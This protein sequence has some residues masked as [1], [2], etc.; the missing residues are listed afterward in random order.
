MKKTR[1]LLSALLL[2]SFCFPARAEDVKTFCSQTCSLWPKLCPTGTLCVKLCKIPRNL[3]Q[4]CRDNKMPLDTEIPAIPLTR[5]QFC[6]HFCK[7]PPFMCAAMTYCTQTCKTDPSQM[8]TCIQQRIPLD[9]YR[10][11]IRG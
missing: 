10:P 5:V 8:K 2:L 9:T 7:A 11:Q 4:V 1:L 6:E 3:L